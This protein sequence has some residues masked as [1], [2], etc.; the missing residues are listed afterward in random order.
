MTKPKGYIPQKERKKILLMCDDIRM[1]SGVANVGKDLVTHLAHR[2]NW[3]NLGGAINHPDQG[4]KLDLSQ[5]T[6]SL[7]G[8]DDSS[9][10]VIPTNGYGDPSLLRQVMELEKP[11]A[12]FLITDP[13]YWMWL[14]QMENEIRKKIPIIYLSI[15]DCPP[16]PAFNRQFYESCDLNLTISKQTKNLT[17]IALE[18]SNVNLIDLDL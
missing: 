4:K 1:W 17:K 16:S 5:E 11:D 7:L 13:R 3:I 15:W 10:F 8:I 9:V 12:I 6:N 2:Y 14:F 18:D